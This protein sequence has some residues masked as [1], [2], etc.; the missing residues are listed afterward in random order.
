VELQQ[1]RVVEGGDADE[2]LSGGGRADSLQ[3]KGGADTLKGRGGDDTLR[4]GEGDDLLIGGA[5]GDDLFGGDGFDI[6][7]Y[8]SAEAGV[9]INLDSGAGG[10][11]FGD[12]FTLVEGFELTSLEDN[13][14]GGSTTV[15]V[16]VWGRGGNDHL[17]GGEGDDVLN[18]G[19]GGDFLA[20]EGGHD[21]VSYADAR[22]GITLTLSSFS[23]STGEAHNDHF[24]EVEGFIL[25][26]FDDVLT[27]TFLDNPHGWEVRAGAGADRVFGFMASDTIDGEAGNDT[28]DGG[29]AAD[30]LSGGEGED[31]LI[32]DIGADVVSGGGGADRFL[33]S[34]LLESRT[35]DGIDRITD[36][37]AAEGDFIDLAQIDA[38]ID[39]EGD[40]AF[41]FVAEFTGRAGQ[42]TLSFEDGLTVFRGDTNGDEVA[43]LIIEIVGE[44]SQ[45]TGWVL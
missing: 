6:A 32:G 10:G 43:D 37:N 29:N 26:A 13:F 20:G 36:F 35:S 23:E 27:T 24:T 33:Y 12:S 15:G 42:A 7:S 4:G 31:E 44:V 1:Y 5:G 34:F 41:R 22:K 21:L 25:T 8:R 14:F 39:R 19:R 9:S 40:Q 28:L 45:D 17:R 18:G 11:A 2:T 3:G 16:T 38:R 30:V